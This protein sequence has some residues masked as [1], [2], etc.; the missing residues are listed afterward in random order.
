MRYGWHLLVIFCTLTLAA[1]GSTTTLSERNVPAG[2]VLDCVERQAVELQSCLARFN[3]TEV[4]RHESS[5]CIT[6]RCDTLFESNSVLIKPA[7]CTEIA[8][9]AEV[10]KKYPETKI[11]VEAHTDCVRSEEENI[12]LS[13]LQAWTIKKALVDGGVASSR[14]TARGW[15]ESRPVASNATE[16]GRKVNR[17]ITIMLTTPNQS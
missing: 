8:T 9:V 14:V 6:I 16:A 15:G 10:V 1:C 7:I 5:I 11:K 17:R 2:L 4:E 13:D 12:A 3:G